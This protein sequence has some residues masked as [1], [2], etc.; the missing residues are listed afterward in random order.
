MDYSSLR[1]T[2][3]TENRIAPPLETISK[4]AKVLDLSTAE[5]LK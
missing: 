5:L 1:S 2:N 3:D 4:L